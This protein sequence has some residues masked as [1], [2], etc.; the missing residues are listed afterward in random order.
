MKKILIAAFLFVSL[1]GIA[2]D[3]N[4]ANTKGDKQIK[5]QQDAQAKQ[6]AL[7][8]AVDAGM[9]TPVV[10]PQANEPTADE[11]AHMAEAEKRNAE[12]KNN[13]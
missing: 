4:K 7:Q 10:K 1:Q 2:Q 8:K 11:K 3:K 6:Q 12:L 5:E 9:K 13:K